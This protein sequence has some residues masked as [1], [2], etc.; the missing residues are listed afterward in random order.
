VRPVAGTAQG[1]LEALLALV[2]GHRTLDEI[3]R[4]MKRRYPADFKSPAKALAYA[5]TILA[6]LADQDA[7]PSIE[8]TE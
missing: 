7:I 2:D 4:E 1:R 6:D 8:R 3:A 5:T